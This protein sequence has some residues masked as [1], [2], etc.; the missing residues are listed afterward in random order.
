MP[1]IG[2]TRAGILVPIVTF[3]ERAGVAA[4]PLLV[5]CGLP[6]RVLDQ[7]ESL[8][9]TVA[10]SRLFAEATH[11]GVADVGL[12]AG[13]EA[14]VEALGVFGRLIRGTPTLQSALDALVRYHTTFSS[15]G[16]VWIA[17]HGADVEV[18]HADGWTNETWQQATH[19]M[20]AIL[21]R[22][23]RLAAGPTWRPAAVRFVSS[24]CPGL[25]DADAL[26]TARIDFSQPV[27]SI[28]VG[29]ELLD[30]PLPPFAGP[31]SAEIDA[32]TAAAPGIDFVRAIGQIIETLSCDGYPSIDITASTVGTSVR[33][34][35]RNLAAVGCTHEEL[36][37][38]A[39]CATA[40]ALL[41]K[42]DS[43]I[44]DIALELGYSDHA[45]FTRAFRRWTGHSPQGFR[46]Q[47]KR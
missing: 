38:Q 47:S 34:L 32:W 11:D 9:P 26:S 45:H 10:T 44:L 16:R 27:T 20:L 13:L 42:T 30:A 8:I 39:R 12:R 37:A 46:H 36:I 28:V 17:L 43:R 23:V 31:S 41:Q 18:C 15:S 4:E 3:L 14:N 25:R 6:I 24:E 5:R 35:Q 2:L 7:P 19:Y 29:R 40:T 21:I 1:P 22:I 33:T